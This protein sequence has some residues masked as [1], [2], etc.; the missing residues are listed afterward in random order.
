MA[1]NSHGKLLKALVAAVLLVLAVQA[2]AEKSE[3]YYKVLGVSKSASQDD[4][5]KAFRKLAKK[6]HPDVNKHRQSWAEKEFIK[7][8]KAYETLSNPEKRKIYDM[9]G[10][11]AVINH[12]RGGQGQGGPGGFQGGFHGGFGGGGM[13]DIINMMFGGG[14]RGGRGGRGGA[15]GFGG[16]FGG[17]EQFFHMGG[18][19]GPF[20]GGRAQGGRQRQRHQGEDPSS[21]PKPQEKVN[22]IEVSLAIPLDDSNMPDVQNLTENWNVFFFDEDSK[23]SP[24]AKWVKAFVE[25][26]GMYLKIG[27]LNC[28]KNQ[29]LCQKLKVSRYPEYHI[30]YQKNKR[31]KVDLPEGLPMEFMVRQNIDLMEQLVQRVTAA[32][33]EDFVKKN[34]ARP[35]VL[36]FTERKQTS[37]LLHSLANM[38][39][40]KVV[41]GEVLSSDPLA[42]RFKVTEYPK[43]MALE[44][45]SAYTGGFYTGSI[46]K[47]SILYWIQDKVMGKRA[48][49]RAQPRELTKERLK[50]GSCGDTD[51][52]FCFIS[53]VRSA[54]LLPKYLAV[55]SELNDRFTSDGI[56]FFYLLEAKASKNELRG[57]FGD[58]RII[59]LRGKRKRFTGFEDDLLTKRTEELAGSLE[60]IVSGGGPQMKGYRSV[61]ALVQ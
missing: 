26:Y 61:E 17:G 49:S 27:F 36:S 18:D 20:G 5:K 14:M 6:Y 43:L 48:T 1:K 46:K 3:D 39:K 11:E 53:I 52:G 4:I 57:S 15:G 34:F 8:N 23:D 51:A 60:N 42:A 12:E 38:L 35:V 59:V 7:V 58:N 41:F 54:D 56:S 10:E 2:K 22:L 40:D 25:K 28:S 9:G 45:P 55:L 21:Q 50:L 13:E 47:D 44:D 37:I 29:G 30:F 19:G 33:Y 31:L 24:Q 32:N 16:G